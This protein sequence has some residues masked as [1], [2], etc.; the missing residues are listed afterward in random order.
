M[1]CIIR[2]WRHPEIGAWLP[3]F[4]GEDIC[5]YLAEHHPHIRR[6]ICTAKPIYELAVLQALAHVVLQKPFALDDLIHAVI[7][8]DAA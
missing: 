5:R 8:S 1:C 4:R 7:G 6:V 2:V 3:G